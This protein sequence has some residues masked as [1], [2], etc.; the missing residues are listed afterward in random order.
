MPFP[1]EPLE[2]IGL[3]YWIRQ[4]PV[5]SSWYLFWILNLEWAWDNS[6]QDLTCFEWV[7]CNLFL[8]IFPDLL[9]DL[10]NAFVR[11]LHK[12]PCSL[13]FCISRGAIWTLFS[14]DRVLAQRAGC[15]IAWHIRKEES[16]KVI[17]AAKIRPF[18]HSISAKKISLER[19]R[20]RVENRGKW[21]SFTPKK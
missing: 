7:W 12:E 18:R 21:F 20:S 1:T 10:V 9:S 15:T 11:R 3:W 4:T 8:C 2:D 16:R 6:G 17:F 19:G 14:K 5:T 13:H